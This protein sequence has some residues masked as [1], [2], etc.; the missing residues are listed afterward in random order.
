MHDTLGST[1]TTEKKK[2]IKLCSLIIFTFSIIP[3]HSEIVKACFPKVMD[4]LSHLAEWKQEKRYLQIFF[5]N[6]LYKNK[7][8]VY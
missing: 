5:E 7:I 1:S 6:S 2:R 4:D 8:W 3:L